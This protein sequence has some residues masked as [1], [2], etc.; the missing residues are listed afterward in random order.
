MGNNL[1]DWCIENDKLHLLSEWD[2]EK[3]APLTPDQIAPKIDKKVWW[4]CPDGHQWEASI[5]QRTYRKTG[6]PYCYGRKV[7]P[8]V[9]DLATLAPDLAAE[10]NHA[11]NEGLKPSE[12]ACHS[13]KKVWW[14]CKQGHEWVATI[15]NR[16]YGTGCPTC[17][18]AC[19]IE[20]LSQHAVRRGGS[21]SERRPQLA[22]QWHPFKN[23]GVSPSAVAAFSSK[24]VWWLCS[25]CGHEWSAVVA[26]RSNGRGCP[27]CAAARRRKPRKSI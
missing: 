9:N 3:N 17:S 2:T 25:D 10:W 8:G 22:A 21:L 4:K 1:H 26:S 11:K 24:R 15:N 6:C 19:K 7:I 12:V 13:A 23:E 16:S 20:K 14:Q 5:W 18:N 27:N